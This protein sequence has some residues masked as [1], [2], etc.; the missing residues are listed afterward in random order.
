MQIGFSLCL[1]SSFMFHLRLYQLNSHL[2]EH[3]PAMWKTFGSGNESLSLAR[4]YYSITKL[5]TE[6]QVSDKSLDIRF[7]TLRRLHQSGAIGGVVVIAGL[8]YEW[9]F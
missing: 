1:A 4:Q 9:L 7:S 2:R 3:Y 6:Y 5:S 8:I